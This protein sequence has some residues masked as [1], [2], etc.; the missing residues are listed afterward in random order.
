MTFRGWFRLRILLVDD[1]LRFRANMCAF[2]ADL[3][4]E[5]FECNEESFAQ[6]D[7]NAFDL[8]LINYQT[9]KQLIRKQQLILSMKNRKVVFAITVDGGTMEMAIDA[10]R[11]GAVDFFPKPVN[12]DHLILLLKKLDTCGMVRRNPSSQLNRN[13]SYRQHAMDTLSMGIFSEK[14]EEVVNLAYKYATIRSFPIIIQGETGTGKEYIAKIIH[15]GER[16]RSKAGA[17]ID[18]NCAALNTSL[19]ESE[20]FGYE[21]G[22]YTGGL[23]RGN[24]GKLDLAQ[25]GT[26]FLDE[27]SELSLESQ[28]K[29]LRVLQ[30]K[31]FYRVGG[32]KKI[33]TNA[34]VIA[35]TNVNLEQAML[36]GSFRKDLYYRLKI[37]SIVIPPLR[38][39]RMEILPLALKFLQDFAQK[40]GNQ[41]FQ[42]IDKE[43][44]EILLNYP[45]YGNVRELSNFM[46]LVSFMYQGDHLRSEHLHMI[47]QS[48]L[49]CK[50][51]QLGSLKDH[52]DEYVLQVLKDS[53]G[54]KSLA[55]RQLGISRRSLYRKL[56][57]L[58]I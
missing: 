54:N 48:P 39:R 24:K 30:E 5:I 18:L 32:L 28:G 41:G 4:H 42:F 29:L 43:A 2:L 47:Q 23:S 55:A 25:G 44:A 31:E 40:E 37:G 16:D 10:M 17:F 9:F 53:Q 58:E 7:L 51:N 14:L 20:I 19:F 15:Y 49:Q 11:W 8:T 56:E 34:R 35:A 3:E 36:E 50:Q 38:E 52:T 26:L 46:E 12:T 6:F 33:S 13:Y 57:N 21:A 22:S 1:D 27:L 45:W